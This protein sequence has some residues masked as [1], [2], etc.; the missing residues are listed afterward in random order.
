MTGA[1]CVCA[2]KVLRGVEREGNEGAGGSGGGTKDEKE[3]VEEGTLEKEDTGTTD[4]NKGD[5]DTRALAQ[6]KATPP[7][8]LPFFAT[9]LPP[10]NDSTNVS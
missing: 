7:T 5:T 6:S 4:D 1:V 3:K 2:T 9:A 10:T 8:T